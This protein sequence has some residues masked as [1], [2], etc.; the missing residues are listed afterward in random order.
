MPLAHVA[1]HVGTQCLH[2]EGTKQNILIEKPSGAGGASQA[3]GRSGGPAPASLLIE[4]VQFERTG[5]FN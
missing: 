1:N 4:L 5:W 2:P 3:L